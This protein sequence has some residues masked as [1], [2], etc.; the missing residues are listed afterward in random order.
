MIIILYWSPYILFYFQFIL[1]GYLQL[2][3]GSP[4][5]EFNTGRNLLPPWSEVHF[6]TFI[7]CFNQ[8]NLFLILPSFSP[9]PVTHITFSPTCE[10]LFKVL[11]H[12]ATSSHPVYLVQVPIHVAQRGPA[13]FKLSV[14]IP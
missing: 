4:C 14:Q 13:M 5:L 11:S 9:P 1:K 7:V 12:L 2:H 6:P 8:A 10:H 3:T